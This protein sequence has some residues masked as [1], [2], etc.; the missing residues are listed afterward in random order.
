LVHSLLLSF[1][2]ESQLRG[3]EDLE[4]L[5]GFC[6]IPQVFRRHID[7]EGPELYAGEVARLVANLWEIYSRAGRV[8]ILLDRIFTVR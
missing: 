8:S 1:T 2:V 3:H 5:P 4:T 7:T 6:P